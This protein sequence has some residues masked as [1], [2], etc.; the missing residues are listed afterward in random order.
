[1]NT[2]QRAPVHILSLAHIPVRAESTRCAYSMKVYN[3]CRMLRGLG[4]PVTL[5]GLA[6]SDTSI[7]D[8]FVECVSRETWES[9]YGKHDPV[10]YQFDW[11]TGDAAW[12][13]CRR[14]AG[15]ELVRHF[16][17]CDPA[18]PEFVLCSF[19]W[20]H[21]PSTRR[22][23][24]N[25]IVVESGIGYRSSFAKFRVFESHAV[26]H[27]TLAR[28]K[29]NDVIC[30]QSY[31][32]VIPNYYDPSHFDFAAQKQSYFLYMGRLNQD[33]GYGIALKACKRIGAKLICVG[34]LPNPPDG[35]AAKWVINQIRDAGGRY[36]PSV[37][38]GP[39]RQLLAGATALFVPSQY[40][41]PFGGVHMEAAF[42]GTPVITSDWGV[43]PETVLQGITGYR[44]TTLRE[45]TWAAAHIDR[46]DPHDCRQ[47]AMQ[48]F[49]MDAI[50]PRY[51]A[52]FQR[53]YDLKLGRDWKWVP[54][55]NRD[56]GEVLVKRQRYPAGTPLA[57]ARIPQPLPS[58]AAG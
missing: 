16:Q 55:D 21:E 26:Y 11:S 32:T 19:G 41:E 42:S 15:F 49:T 54:E 38:P 47:W 36:L 57:E 29:P 18:R 27:A 58:E 28:A 37:G 14:R 22:L 33:K 53:L 52:Y 50:G 1:M 25:A 43:F 51:D 7:A 9:V 8:D 2:M 20:A 44:C 46:I 23:P 4:Y 31:W 10:T 40:V 34:Q 24:D 12:Q 5:Y 35:D 39:R 48:N 6:G 13:E 30:G 56:S 17:S 45:Y 3:L